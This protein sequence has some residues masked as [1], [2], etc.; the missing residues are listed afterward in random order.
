[1]TAVAVAPGA[2]TGAAEVAELVAY[3]LSEAAGYFSGCR[4]SL[5]ELAPAS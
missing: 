3:L 1:V 4:F 5:G 2:A